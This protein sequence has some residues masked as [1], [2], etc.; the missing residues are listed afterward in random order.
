MKGIEAM[1]KI[2]SLVITIALT[3]SLASVPAVNAAVSEEEG[4]ESLVA[5]LGIMNGD[6]NG[7]MRLD[8][9]VSRAEF[10]KIAVSASAAKNSV[11]V[12]LKTSPFKDVPYTEWFAP[13]VKAAVSAGLVAGYLDATYRPDNTVTYEEAVTIMLRVLGYDDSSFGEAYPYGQIGKAQGLD[14]LDGVDGAIGAEMTRRQVMYLVYNTLQASGASSSQDG[15]A[16]F[17]GTLLSVHDCVMTENADVIST[18]AQDSSLGSDKVFTSAGT[19]TK[20]GYFNDNSVGMT[21]KLFIKNSRDVVAFVPDIDYKSNDYET[22]VVYSVLSDSVVGYNKG[23]FET[24]EI[25]ESAK[26]YKNQTATTYSAVKSGLEMGDTL[27]VKR[28]S[29]GSVDYVTFEE[30]NMIGPVIVSDSGWMASVGAGSSSTIMRGGVKSTAGAIVTNDVVYYSEPLDIVFAYTDKVTGVY[31]KA[32]PTKDSPTTVTISG[33][34]YTIEGVDAFNDL[35]SSGG[36]KY[37]D[38]ITVLLGRT[39]E[40]AGV[41]GGSGSS[42]TE[43]QYGFV[44]E[45]GKKDFTNADNTT[46]SSYY[47]KVVTPDGNENEY[48]TSANYSSQKCAVSRVSFKDGKAVLTRQSTDSSISGTVNA[49]KSTLGDYTLAEDV[50]I[51]DTVGTYSD[52]TA[53][54]ARIYPQRLDGVNISASKVRYYS[55]NS[56][57]EIDKLILN[58]VTGDSYSYGIILSAE[59]SSG[60]YKVDIDGTQST[61]STSFRSSAT[62]PHKFRMDQSG[63]DYMQALTAYSSKISSLTATEAKIGSQTYTLSDNAIVYHK[64]GVN[65]YMKI[66]LNDAIEGGYKMTAYYDKAQSSG[67]RIRIII[68]E[69]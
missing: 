10:A 58:D 25:P 7:D 28:T 59:S 52:D 61:Y 63:V 53:M 47:A 31:E 4:V 64:T 60:T 54:Y 65:T 19:Y 43:V 23:G 2:I 44:I 36:F 20:G 66:P 40:I 56:S 24:I 18:S 5:A 22:Y 42:S 68:A 17:S 11:A 1:K 33:K 8:S 16:S 51:L 50:Q 37:G 46:Y 57:G 39:G 62:G 12:G 3:L 55:K 69:D 49:S 6:E 13:Y 45:T 38:T 27:Y 14:M 67:G 21:G 35:S 26:V 32:S 41:V 34:E 48:T 9:Y 15:S 29:G 30:S